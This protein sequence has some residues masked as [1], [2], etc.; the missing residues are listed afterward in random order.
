LVTNLSASNYPGAADNPQGSGPPLILG[1][2]TGTTGGRAF[3]PDSGREL[4]GICKKIGLELKN[5]YILGYQST[6]RA[7]DRRW[8]KVKVKTVESKGI[9]RLSV[10]AQKGYYVSSTETVSK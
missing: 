6:N 7:K 8:R 10:R 4:D 3:Y 9:P 5:Q 2:L 1:D